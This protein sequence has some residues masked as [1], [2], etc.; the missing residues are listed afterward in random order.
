MSVEEA[1]IETPNSEAATVEETSTDEA[2]VEE[3]EAVI[4]D[5]PITNDKPAKKGRGIAECGAPQRDPAMQQV[6]G[7]VQHRQN[8]CFAYERSNSWGCVVNLLAA[9]VIVS[10]FV[11]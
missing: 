1:T 2:V 5:D 7:S 3:P 4:A 11:N 9:K 6:Y 8:I 10:K